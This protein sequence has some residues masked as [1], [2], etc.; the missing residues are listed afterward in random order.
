MPR[1][2]IMANMLQTMNG[3]G[4]CNTRTRHLLV[5][6]SPI[7][8]NLSQPIAVAQKES[9]THRHPRC[10]I[11]HWAREISARHQLHQRLL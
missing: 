3:L 2:S 6:T 1:L 7:Y 10:V 4:A 5:V 8:I 11:S 9:E